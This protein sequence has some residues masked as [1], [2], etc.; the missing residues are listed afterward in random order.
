[1]ATT[2]KIDWGA[3]KAPF[4]PSDIEW[5]IAQSGV[6]Q[7][8]TV[9]AK[10]LAYVDNRSIMDRCDEVLGPENWKEEYRQ[11]RDF[12][13]LDS[14]GRE[15]S[16]GSQICRIYYRVPGG[17]EWLWKE[18]GAPDTQI[19]G[20]KGGLSDSMKRAGVKLG[21]GRYLYKL[22]QAWAETSL[23]KPAKGEKGWNFATDVD[24]QTKKRT[25]YWWRPPDLPQYALPAKYVEEMK[26]AKTKEKPKAEDGF[27]GSM[28]DKVDWVAEAKKDMPSMDKKKLNGWYKK[29]V[30]FIEQGGPEVV[31]AVQKV[32][33]IRYAELEREEAEIQ[34]ESD[35]T[36]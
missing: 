14:K 15:V 23:T 26:K 12:K 35:I 22:P 31:K 20:I 6:K 18:C 7:D 17:A 25:N 2:K 29:R 33:A 34:D 36:S 1:M 3:M 21:I 32:L 4:L 27:Y 13:A 19:E 5:R 16:T 9:W 10:C 11:W 28:G 24:K 8:G 30:K